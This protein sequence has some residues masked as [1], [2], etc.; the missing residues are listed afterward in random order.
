VDGGGFVRRVF[1][2]PLL[3]HHR[4]SKV[5]RRGVAL[6]LRPSWIVAGSTDRW[7]YH[8]RRAPSGALDGVRSNESSEMRSV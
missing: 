3:S 7:D 2:S 4:P 6:C 8:G 1:S 5:R